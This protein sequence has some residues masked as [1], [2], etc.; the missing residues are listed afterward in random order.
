MLNLLIILSTLWN[1]LSSL[2]VFKG[3][4]IR[5]DQSPPGTHLNTHITDSHPGFHRHI[6]EGRSGIFNKIA[7]P[8]ASS[9]LGNDIQN[10]I[11]GNNSLSQFT[12]HRDPHF[13]RLIL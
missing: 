3:L 13:L 1:K 12:V 2:Q 5:G 6:P 9:E 11:L 10:N 8:T 7:G 4:L